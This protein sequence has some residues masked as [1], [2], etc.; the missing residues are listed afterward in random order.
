MIK[1]VEVKNLKRFR[2]SCFELNDSIVL[3]GPNNAGKSTLLQG[4]ATWKLGLDAWISQRK[5]DR[6]RVALKRTGVGIPRAN[7]TT[8]P[9]REMNL[10]WED[11]R[12]SD[13]PGKPRLVEIIVKGE[14]EGKSWE[15]G[16]E[17]QYSHPELIYVR[18]LHAKTLSA[19]KILEFPPVA[20][21]ELEVVYIPP[22]SGIERDEPRRELGMQNLLI[23][24][25]RPGEILRNL[26]WEIADLDP[27]SWNE[28]ANIIESLFGIQILEPSYSPIQPY[29]VCEYRESKRSRPL[30]LSNVGSGTLQVLLLFAFLFARPATVILVDE[31]DAHQHII[32]QRQVYDLLRKAARKRKGQFI[33]A[34]HSEVVLDATEPN[35]VLSFFGNTPHLLVNI[36]DRDRVREALKHLTTTDLVLGDGVGS[37]L[38]VEG[39]TDERILLEWAKIIDHPAQDFL[40]SPVIHKLN[41]RKPKDAKVHFFAMKAVFPKMRAI[42]LLDGDNREEEDEQLNKDG[43]VTLRWNRYEIENYLLHPEAIKR[44]VGN[45]PLLTA[46]VDAAFK[47]H[48]PENVDF[49]G[50]NVSLTR[51]KASEEFLVPLLDKTGNNTPKKDLYLLASVMTEDEIH[52]EVLDKLDR[53]AEVLKLPAATNDPA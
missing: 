51:I 45:Q 29:I 15:C 53:I 36:T 32:L 26:L 42:C 28:L 31:P 5:V 49:F 22:L 39:D 47:E 37:I 35:R 24:L 30:D 6:K 23:G 3:A 4:I 1:S 50:D 18:P 21:E 38:Y 14:T 17:F 48:M 44:F 43:L 33:V 46:V 10:L 9:L 8:V 25:G 40:E 27:D 16:L 11:R 19:E 7:L 2:G 12:V 34:T 20:A 13:G 41:G 52:H